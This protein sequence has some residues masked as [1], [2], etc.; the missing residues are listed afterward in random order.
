MAKQQKNSNHIFRVSH[1]LIVWQTNSWNCCSQ[2]HKVENVG[3]NKYSYLDS[4]GKMTIII[5]RASYKFSIWQ[6]YN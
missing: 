4:I 3:S 2:L 1:K 6:I 5:S